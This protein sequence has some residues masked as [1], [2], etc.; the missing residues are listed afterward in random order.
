MGKLIYFF[1]NAQFLLVLRSF[2]VQCIESGKNPNRE[3][4]LLTKPKKS[5]KEV[6]VEWLFEEAKPYMKIK[7]TGC[8]KLSTKNV[9]LFKNPF[10]AV[11][12]L[13]FVHQC[14]LSIP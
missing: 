12:V 7:G 2:H 14:K 10:P 13:V 1:F 3:K 11:L 9:L 8:C 4:K 6:D 5:N